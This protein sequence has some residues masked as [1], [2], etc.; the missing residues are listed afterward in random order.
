M[1]KNR[2]RELNDAFRRTFRGGRVMMTSGVYELPDCVKAE[3]LVQVTKISEFSADNDPHDEHDFGSF[4]LV[5][6]KFFWKIDLY[7]EPDVKD[8][9]GDPVVNRVLTIMLASEY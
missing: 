6:R 2:I 9:N 8:A 4:N 7:E 1:S 5:G 3:A